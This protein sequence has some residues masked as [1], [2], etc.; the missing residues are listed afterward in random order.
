MVGGVV[1]QGLDSR[2]LGPSLGGFEDFDPEGLRVAVGNVLVVTAP[3]KEVSD[4]GITI[5][6]IARERSCVARVAAIPDDENCPVEVGFWVV[7]RQHAGTPVPFG[8][9]KDLLV[10]Q[11][12]KGPASDILGWF[13]VHPLTKEVGTL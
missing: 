5:P 4:G 8:K 12:D 9:R 1:E 3:D 2:I 10:L 7:F 11:Y 6:E 13:T